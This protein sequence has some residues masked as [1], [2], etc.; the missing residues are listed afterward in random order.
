MAQQPPVPPQ[1]AGY[2]S[3]SGARPGG[4]T[5][6]AVILIVV[7]ALGVIFGLI[8]AVGGGVV[9]ANLSGGLGGAAIVIA[10]LVLAFAIVEIIAG[11]KI[12]GLNDTWRVVGIVVAAVALAFTVI[13]LFGA[14]AGSSVI[15]PVSGAQLDTGP[16]VGSIIMNLIFIAL[17]VF[18][19]MQLVKNKASFGR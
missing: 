17:Y 16:Q 18:V 1:P 5:A 10:L 6:A 7:G 3:A 12:L 11:V 14:F 15:D 9:A 13:G 8:A 19:I 4:V 2:G